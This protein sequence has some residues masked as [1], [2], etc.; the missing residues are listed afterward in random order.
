MSEVN[1]SVKS[2]REMVSAGY[3]TPKG[4]Q[5]T[6]LEISDQRDELL[7]ALKDARVVLDRLR[8]SQGKKFSHS[9]ARDG[10]MVH[11]HAAIVE[12]DATIAKVTQS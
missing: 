12:I 11:V 4:D 5:I 8:T 10:V 3:I 6:L 2:L 9:V 1:E 7:A